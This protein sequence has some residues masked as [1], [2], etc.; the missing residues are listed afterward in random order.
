MSQSAL[1]KQIPTHLQQ[2]AEPRL[3]TGA[4]IELMRIHNDLHVSQVGMAVGLNTAAIYGKKSSHA[5]LQS[6]LAILLRL[7][8]AAPEYLPCVSTPS[9]PQLLSKIK[10][11]EPE[12]QLGSIGPLL[13]I[14]SNGSYR[15]RETG[16]NEASQTSRMLA[17]L[18]YRLLDEKGDAGWQT[19][20]CAIE[21]EAAARNICPPSEVWRSGG[22]K[23]FLK[24]K[25]KDAAEQPAEKSAASKMDDSS[26]PPVTKK[27][28]IRNRP[29]A[30]EQPET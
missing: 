29:H 27:L 19:I 28:V 1:S 3:L 17:W 11:H 24:K 8:A 5:P 13:G 21:T 2:F 25:K 12:F 18:I 14:E 4:D 26:A 16:F 22:W 7:Y 6:A 9:V 10:E 23:K 30:I 15:R 20:K